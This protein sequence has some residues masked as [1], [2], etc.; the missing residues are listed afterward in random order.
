MKKKLGKI[1]LVS[2]LIATLSMLDF[3]VLG[4]NIAIAMEEQRNIS[5]IE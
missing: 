1:I 5:T 4:Q 2:I 3:I